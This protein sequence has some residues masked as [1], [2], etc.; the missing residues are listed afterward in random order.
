[1]HLQP[2]PLSWWIGLALLIAPVVVVAQPLPDAD[3][4]PVCP[5][6]GC[7]GDAPIVIA[8]DAAEGRLIGGKTAG[9][10]P[11]QVS[12][13][14]GGTLVKRGTALPEWTL[15]HSCGGALIAPDWVLTAGHCIVVE[16]TTF[17]TPGNL[18]VRFG[19]L[20][21]DSRDL[22]HVGVKRIVRHPDYQREPTQNDVALLQLDRPVTLQ[23]GL[24]EVIALPDRQTAVGQP[25]QLSGWGKTESPV[26]GGMPVELRFIRLRVLNNSACVSAGFTKV[27]DTDL[28]AGAP[29][30]SQCSGD[31]GGPLVWRGTDAE[32][33]DRWV[34]VGSVSRSLTNCPAGK[35][36]VY[37]RIASFTDWIRSAMKAAATRGSAR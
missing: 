27:S 5:P 29:D 15:R 20:R 6:G 36:G 31:S 4:P 14:Y 21:L 19:A 23:P 25:V 7:D 1:M 30:V 22:K 26:A 17:M 13:S 32:G 8:P 3:A 2:A 12:V 24:V 35:P 18:E 10:T 11:W 37:A 28:C 34:L 9:P 33:R 16:K